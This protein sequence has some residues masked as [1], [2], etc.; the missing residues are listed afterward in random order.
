MYTTLIK[1][2]IFDLKK[3]SDAINCLLHLNPILYALY[4]TCS[5]EQTQLVV[6]LGRTSIPSLAAHLQLLSASDGRLSFQLVFKQLEV[7]HVADLA[8][9]PKKCLSR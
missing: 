4:P 8:V 2:Q 1:W 5:H 9:I 7:K 3:L 6:E